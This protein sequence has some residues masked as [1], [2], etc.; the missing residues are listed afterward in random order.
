MKCERLVHGKSA[1]KKI[2]CLIVPLLLCLLTNANSAEKVTEDDREYRKTARGEGALTPKMIEKCVK[3]KRDI[4]EQFSNAEEEKSE[5]ETRDQELQDLANELE[6]SRD[7]VDPSNK[8]A[9]DEFNKKVEILNTKTAEYTELKE[10]Y[11]AQIEPYKKQKK[12][13]LKGCKDQLYYEDDYETVVKKLG[14]GM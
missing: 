9:I 12:K 3:L 5:L 1:M 4:D 10:Q 2:T 11:N 6:E 14:Y 7:S 8:A 13:F